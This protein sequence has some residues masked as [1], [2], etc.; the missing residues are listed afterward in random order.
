MAPT[1]ASAHIEISPTWNATKP[2]VISIKLTHIDDRPLKPSMMLTEF[3]AGHG[4][5]CRHQQP[6][7]VATIN[8]DRDV[9]A[10]DLHSTAS[11]CA[12]DSGRQQAF[13]PATLSWSS[14]QSNLLRK[15]AIRI[16]T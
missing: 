3:A 5:H 16:K 1:P 15:P 13:G 2:N 4:K 11:Q 9:G 7:V 6:A 12:G 10:R 8:R 14:L